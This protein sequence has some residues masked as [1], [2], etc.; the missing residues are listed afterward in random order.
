MPKYVLKAAL[1]D[2][3]ALKIKEDCAFHLELSMIAKEQAD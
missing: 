3:V 1:D 2:D